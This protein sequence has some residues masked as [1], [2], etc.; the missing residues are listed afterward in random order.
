MA[1]KERQSRRAVRTVVGIL[2]VAGVLCVV[3]TALFGFEEP[4]NTL[5]VLCC[6]LLVAPVIVVFT[7]LYATRALTS[8]ERRI[9]FQQLTGRRA[10]W[11]ITEYLNCDDLA[12]A[13]ANLTQVA[14]GRRD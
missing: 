14:P 10:L 2:F 5:V 11:A 9:W 7:D 12:A 8:S 6:G 13:A 3:L 4:S 1:A